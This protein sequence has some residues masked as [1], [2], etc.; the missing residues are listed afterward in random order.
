M[1]SKTPPSD[2][3]RKPAAPTRRLFGLGLVTALVALALSLGGGARADLGLPILTIDN[4]SVDDGTAVVTG[5]ID[6]SDLEINGV[7]VIV[8]DAGQFNVTVD[9]TGNDAGLNLSFIGLHSEDIDI[10]VPI[11]LLQD[12]ASLN[13]VLDDLI[14]AGVTI[15]VPVDGFTLIDG[16]A[17]EVNGSV[18]NT[19]QLAS[20]MVNDVNVLNHLTLGGLFSFLVPPSGSNNNNVVFVMVD[21]RG[22][23]QT[24]TFR[25]TSAVR[26]RTATSVSAASAR[27]L[28]IAR[29]QINRTKLRSAQ[30]FRMTVTVK[31]RRGLLVRGAAV[32]LTTKPGRWTINGPVRAAF[33]NKVGK[34]GFSV[35]LKRAAFPRQAVRQL[36]LLLRASTPRA[37]AQKRVVLRLPALRRA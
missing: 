8:N 25:A 35:K 20:F 22:V 24:S 17:I 6:A 18:L 5:T 21:R 31:D 14:D 32:R 26:T 3:S 28:R 34:A 19:D 29:V 23:S 15:D 9:L 16:E 1:P 12:G 13:R 11:A 37:S 27:G 7:P 2:A 36:A 10:H 4:V 30:T 33:T